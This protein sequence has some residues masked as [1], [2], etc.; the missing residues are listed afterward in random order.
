[1]NEIMNKQ[2]YCGSCGKPTEKHHSHQYDMVTGEAMMK[3]VCSNISCY[4]YYED[5]GVR[6]KSIYENRLFLIF[7]A[8]LIATFILGSCK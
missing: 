8:I 7:G 6:A 5:R 2:C 3:D 1:M 4:R